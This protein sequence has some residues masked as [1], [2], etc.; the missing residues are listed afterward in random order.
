VVFSSPTFLFVFLP[1]VLAA[2]ALVPVRLRKVLLVAASLFFYA[3]GVGGFVFVIVA[4]TL[5][6]WALGRL[7]EGDLQ[8]GRRSRARLLLT[9]SIVQNLALLGYFKYANF[10]V[11]QFSGA[12]ERVGFDASLAAIVLPIGI[13]F[14][15]FEKISYTVDVWRGDTPARRNPLDLLLFVALFPRAIAGP[16]V[17]VAEVAQDIDRPRNLRQDDLVYGVT[18]FA[19]GLAKKVIIADS[20]APVADASFALQG[21]DLTTTAAWV[22]IVAYTLQI[23]FDFSGYSDM[24]IGL[25]RMFG[26]HFAENFN[27]PYS[28]VSVTEFWRR[29]H[30]TLSRWFRDY[31]YI[32]LGGSRGG[33]A[34]MYRNLVLVFLATGFWHG[35]DWTFVIWGAYHGALLVLERVA[36]LRGLEA[37]VRFVPLR[38]AV[39]LLLVM[40]GWVIFRAEDIGAAGHYLRAMFT[41]QGTELGMAFEGVLTHQAL[42]VLALGS[43]VA[44]MPRGLVIGRALAERETPLAWAG[45][46]A[47]VGALLPISLVLVL[48]GTFSA[49]LYFRF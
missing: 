39:T 2:Y 7:I 3:W 19:H 23:Y 30:M 21:G 13:S 4:S 20:V 5:A 44:L 9:A 26:F 36:G 33:Q 37:G 18:R 15:T 16:I 24:A 22:G 45:R 43:L 31:L 27:R 41:P 28:A 14:F 12:L 11:D 10:F 35:A 1:L 32:P 38:R 49:F 6:D 17:R 8:S 40:V 25:G 29:W 46:F 42:F 48:S 34:M 47:V